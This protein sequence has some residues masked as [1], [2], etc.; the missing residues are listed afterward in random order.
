MSRFGNADTTVQVLGELRDAAR[1]Q[2][3]HVD[4]IF[5][6]IEDGNC[7]LAAREYREALTHGPIKHEALLKKQMTKACPA[8]LDASPETF[9]LGTNAIV[10]LGGIAF[11]YYLA[12]KYGAV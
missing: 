6:A 2:E 8:S 10:F 5:T 7:R 1:S 9:V 11:L 3:E 4:A 12:K